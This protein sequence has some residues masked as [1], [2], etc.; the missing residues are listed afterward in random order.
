MQLGFQIATMVLLLLA[1]IQ[2][3][4]WRMMLFCTL[5][6]LLLVAMYFAFGR[7]ASAC[8]CI[9]ATARTLI[10]MIY[11][12]KKLKPNI[13]LLILF[14]IGFVISTALTWQ[15][16]LDLLPMFALMISGFASWQENK[17]ILRIG[18][19]INAILFM[20]YNSVIGA[21][22]AMATKAIGLISSTVALIYYCVWQQKKP[23]LKYFD[24]FNI[25]TKKRK[26]LKE[27]ENQLQT[28]TNTLIEE[29]K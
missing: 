11:A 8:I 21:W 15:D 13:Y 1:M 2:S 6:N 25:F 28:K 3:K 20:S 18:Y 7:I 23:L 12:L 27:E 10:Y 9:V 24:F 17:W 29:H 5:E 4:K 16:A 19:M 22:I 26:K 14:E